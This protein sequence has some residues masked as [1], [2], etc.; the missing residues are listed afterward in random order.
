VP[1]EVEKTSQDHIEPMRDFLFPVLKAMNYIF[2]TVFC[3]C[4]V[5][6]GGLDK[7]M[8]SAGG[9]KLD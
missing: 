7:I 8:P 6:A 4:T 5:L 9:K 1:H 3:K 2:P